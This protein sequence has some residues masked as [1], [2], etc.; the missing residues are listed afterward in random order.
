MAKKTVVVNLSAEV[1]RQYNRQ[2]LTRMR[3][4]FALE[5]QD[6]YHETVTLGKS[7]TITGIA[8]GQAGSGYSSDN[9]PN[10]VIAAP[11]TGG[12]QA[13]A[14]ATVDT[15]GTV[16]GFTV[17]QAGSGYDPANPPAVTITGGGGT[18]ATA[19]A[20]V[21]MGEITASKSFANFLSIYAEGSQMQAQVRLAHPETGVIQPVFRVDLKGFLFLPG[22][23]SFTVQNRS[24]SETV[25]TRLLY[26]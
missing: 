3:R 26:S 7:G 17:T 5:D 8:V 13:T 14:T 4:A 25:E 2:R 23:G 19:T 16:T 11:P 10:V 12:T 21:G 18:G 9:P 1:S 22:S 24:S 15:G 20:T 6:L